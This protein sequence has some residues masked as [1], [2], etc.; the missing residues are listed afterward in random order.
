MTT[1]PPWTGPDPWAVPRP[2]PA[3]RPGAPRLRRGELAVGALALVVLLGAGARAVAVTGGDGSPSSAASTPSP[4]TSPSLSMPVEQALPDLVA[5]VEDT[6]EFEFTADVP[7]EVLDDEAYADRID[8]LRLAGRAGAAVPA[9]S[10]GELSTMIALGLAE[11]RDD[12]QRYLADDGSAAAGLPLYDAHTRQIVVRGDQLTPYGQE[13]MVRELTRAL[14]DQ[15]FDLD[16]RDLTRDQSRALGAL[17]L[18]DATVIEYSW[19][20]E[21]DADLQE[22]I[23]DDEAAFL[24]ALADGPYALQAL[25]AYPVVSGL[26]LAITLLEDGGQ[27]RVDAALDAATA[28]PATTEQVLDPDA[29]APV[30]VAGPPAVDPSG[31]FDLAGGRLVDR[32]TLG[33]TGLALLLAQDPTDDDE[34]FT[35]WRGDSYVTLELPSGRYCIRVDLAVSPDEGELR[36]DLERGDL[37]VLPTAGDRLTVIG[38]A[39]D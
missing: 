28:E 38:C 30:V 5:Y 6:R 20:E 33:E 29:P 32:G 39:A 17:S 10:D 4:S 35:A 9:Y 31:T 13:I 37:V 25:A 18:G 12:L 8:A 36:A 23:E 26:D 24:D 22:A 19:Y 11:S 14:Q 2:L 16:V 1:P 21:Q 7:V 27:E 15:Q 3:G 34:S